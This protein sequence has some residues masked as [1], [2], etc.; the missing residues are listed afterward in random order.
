MKR[1]LLAFAC[2]VLVAALACGGTSSPSAP[3]TPTIVNV[4]GVWNGTTRLTAATGGECVGVLYQANLGATQRVTAQVSQAGTSSMT[5]NWASCQ[6]GVFR[7]QC[8]NGA[9]RDVNL[10]GDTIS[11]TVTGNTMT[12]TDGSSYN[13]FVAGTNIGV[14]M[15]TLNGT[16]SATRQ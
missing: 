1:L 2:A 4:A 7:L 11:A 8:S 13:V 16:F 5:L 3:S 9:Y 14:G 15:L 6:V 10:V 12:G